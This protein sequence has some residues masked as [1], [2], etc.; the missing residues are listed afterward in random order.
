LFLKRRLTGI[1]GKTAL[2]FIG[3]FI[4]IILPVN[5]LIYS[6][7]REILIQADT[8][9]LV[10]EGDKLFGQVRLDPQLIPLPPL[11]YSIFLQA[12]NEFQTDSLFASPDFPTDVPAL[13]IQSPIDIDTLK[14]ITLTRVL[15][16]GNSKLFFSIARSNQR[17][18]MQ[19]G[20]LRM[21]LI[22]GN[23]ASIFIAGL[24]VYLVSGYTLRPIKKIIDVAQRINA[25]KSIERVPV[26]NTDDENQQLA[27]TINAMLQRIE[28]SIKN[29]TNFFASAAHELKTPLAVMQT[30]LSVML[31]S[32][33]EE[34]TTRVLQ[35]QLE[36]VQRLDRVIQD[37]LLISQLKSETLAL[38]MKED[39]LDEA[40]YSAIKR[41]KYQAKDKQIQL[42]VTMPNEAQAYLCKFDFDKMETVFTNLVENAIKYSIDQSIVSIQLLKSEKVYVVIANPVQR[43]VDDIDKLKSEFKKSN[44]LSAGLGMGLWISDQ[45]MNLQGGDLVLSQQE[46]HF[47]AEVYL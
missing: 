30:E 25:S 35:N 29:Q 23:L 2:I 19:L 12:G 14:I 38:R 27:Q 39:R 22:A 26:P 32:V 28:N 20:E 44:E 17:I 36:E 41:C 1:Q 8:K 10:N 18:E 13:A 6:K 37:F 3:V 15:E 40:L 34:Q 11:G 33:T 43:V 47:V 16:Y 5:S 24:L 46:R 31:N 9:E 4:I 21:Y 42:K 45:L 7:V